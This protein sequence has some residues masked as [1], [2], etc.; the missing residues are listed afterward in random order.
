MAKN[1][2]IREKISSHYL[3]KIS[4]KEDTIRVEEWDLDILVKPANLTSMTKINEYTERED[5]IG[6]MITMV[7]ECCFAVD[8]KKMFEEEDREFLM[9]DADPDVV[10]ELGTKVSGL[11][12]TM[13]QAGN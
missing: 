11:A 13:K 3:E 12:I 9:N 2:G 7:I 8:G 5:N 1:K 6:A 4:G 10:I